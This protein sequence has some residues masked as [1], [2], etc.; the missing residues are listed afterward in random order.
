MRER[1]HS[2]WCVCSEELKGDRWGAS[3]RDSIALRNGWEL[4][5]IRFL[6]S[7]TVPYTGGSDNVAIMACGPVYSLEGCLRSPGDYQANIT[8]SPVMTVG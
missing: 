8:I 1:D 5:S 7:G 3:D 2:T 6:A 4:A